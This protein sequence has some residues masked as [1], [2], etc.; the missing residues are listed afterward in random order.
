M[1]DVTV[2][3]LTENGY[4]LAVSYGAEKIILGNS[5]NYI[6]AGLTSKHLH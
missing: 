5:P 1:R 4:R 6:F 3:L 2:A